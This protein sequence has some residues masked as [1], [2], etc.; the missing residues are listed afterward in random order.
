MELATFLYITFS[1]IYL[2]IV[3]STVL[4]IV[5]DNRQPVKTVAWILVV[6]SMPIL[7]LIIYFFFG[8]N[9]KKNL[10]ISRTC[11]IQLAR[12]SAYRYFRTRIP[13]IPEEHRQL[14]N[15][16]RRQSM[17]FPYPENQVQLFTCGKDMLSALLGDIRAA[18]HHIHLEFYIWEDDRVG[19]L[20]LEELAR[21]VAE[22]VKVRVVYDDVGCWRVKNAFFERMRSKGIEVAVFLP[23]RFPILTSKVNFRNHRKIVVIDGAVGY[24]GGMNLADRYFYDAQDRMAWRDSHLRIEGSS[25]SGL[26]RAFLADWYVAC[27]ELITDAC[28]Y[29]TDFQDSGYAGDNSMK[30]GRLALVQIV[31]SMPTNSWQDIMQGMVLALLRAKKYCFIQSPYFMPTDR[32]LYAMQTAA[33]SGVDVRLMLPERADTKLLTW[34]SR[35]YLTDV[36]RAGVRV[37]LYQGTFLHAKTWVSD[38]SL[39]SCGSTNM[40]FRSLEHN[41]EVNAFIFDRKMALVMRHTFLEDQKKCRLLNLNAWE[42]RSRWRRWG[43]SFIRLLSPL[44]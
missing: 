39:S 3:C 9:H 22:G 23:V 4:V 29:P 11:S 36:M 30:S 8:R 18:R 38:D 1:V 42:K 14:V 21:K 27:E 37:Y 19:N 5:L 12:R 33:L 40:D 16:F 32:L 24:V 35:A 26:Q 25:V 10:L 7:G 2:L 43:E 15:L 13:D 17:A 28:Y 20:V 34:A 31:T 41:F 44:L 6:S